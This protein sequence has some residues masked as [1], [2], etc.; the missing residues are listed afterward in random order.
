METLTSYYQIPNFEE[1]LHIDF[2]FDNDQTQI[3]NVKRVLVK[4]SVL[5]NNRNLLKMRCTQV[6]AD[7]MKKTAKL[8]IFR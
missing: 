8:L 7:N 3:N 1:Q 2:I 6:T 4:G 5:L